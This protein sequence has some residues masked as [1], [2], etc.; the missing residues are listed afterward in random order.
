[1]NSNL[2]TCLATGWPGSSAYVARCNCFMGHPIIF[3]FYTEGT[4]ALLVSSFLHWQIQ[5]AAG[6]AGSV[7]LVGFTWRLRAG[8]YRMQA[9]FI[10][11]VVL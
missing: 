2:I 6:M 10:P 4:F 7:K 1:M 8:R 9:F 3:S 5:P 11:G